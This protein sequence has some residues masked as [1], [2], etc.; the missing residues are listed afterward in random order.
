M[1]VSTHWAVIPETVSVGVDC[2][3]GFLS[4]L[5]EPVGNVGSSSFDHRFGSFK[6]NV[7]L[8]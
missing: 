2:H 8:D 1:K 6:M 5:I 4:V 7:L 3:F